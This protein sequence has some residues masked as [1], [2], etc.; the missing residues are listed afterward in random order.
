MIAKCGKTS[1]QMMRT[2]FPDGHPRRAATMHRCLPRRRAPARAATAKAYAGIPS[3]SDPRPASRS[4]YGTRRNWIRAA[5]SKGPSSTSGRGAPLPRKLPHKSRL[6]ALWA[7]WALCQ[8][9]RLR[10]RSPRRQHPDRP[11]QAR[12]DR[13]TFLR[14]LRVLSELIWIT[15]L[16]CRDFLMLFLFRCRCFR[17]R[18]RLL[19]IPQWHFRRCHRCSRCHRCRRFRR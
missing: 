4:S 13:W 3:A 6:W 9:S 14:R 2:L 18:P 12:S 8:C 16:R 1:P 5:F 17:A 10:C 15:S 19:H 7:L 11:L